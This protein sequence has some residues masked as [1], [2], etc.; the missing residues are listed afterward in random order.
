MAVTVSQYYHT[1]KLLLNKEVTFTTLKVML[2]D[3]T[4]SFVGTHT[5]VDSVAGVLTPPRAKE[6][7]GNGWTQG[8]ELIAGVAVTQT[9]LGGDSINNDATL[10]GTDLVKTASGGPLP[11]T[12]AYYEL[13]Y[14]ST[15]MKPLWLVSYGQAQQAGDT[16]DFKSRW[17]SA[18]GIYNVQS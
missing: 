9:T 11:P 15:S 14:D 8:G 1:N 6:L 18:G 5:T 4:A 13:I 17:N 12:A 3:N 7:Y 2:L 16:T 10:T